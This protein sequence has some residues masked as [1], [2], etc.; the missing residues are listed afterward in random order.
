VGEIE[1]QDLS[2]IF[3]LH[4]IE[5]VEMVSFQ[6]L[7]MAATKLKDRQISNLLQENYDQAKADRVLLL[8]ISS[9]YMIN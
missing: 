4:N 2:I 6:I 8:L 5:N 3:Y 7:Q 1:L 9:K